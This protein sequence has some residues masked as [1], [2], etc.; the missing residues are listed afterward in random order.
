MAAEPPSAL[1]SLAEALPDSPGV[2]TFHGDTAAPLYIGKSVNIRRRV[3][4]HLRAPAGARL[5]RLTQRFS[6]V[7]TAGDIGAQLLEA[8][9]V[10]LLQPLFNLRLRRNRR[11]CTIILAGGTPTITN[12]HDAGDATSF[13]LFPSRLAAT[14][15]LRKLADDHGL[16][17]G[18]LGIETLAAGR[19]CFRYA[20]KRCTG[21]CC[22]EET[23]AE[24]R[25]RLI[26]ALVHRHVQAW[27]YQ[28]SIGIIEKS[29]DLRQ[30]LVVR[31]WTYLGSAAT[32]AQARKLDRP[33]TAFDRDGYRIL[34]QPLL[35]R[36]VEVREL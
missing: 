33:A 9:Q 22:G 16:C 4:E 3:L 32:L 31:N 29:G 28:G 30:I 10:K 15:V 11:L 13:G 17:Y 20:L 24:H 5:R 18:R 14:E 12:V 35:S 26:G 36:T 7:R 27:P 23:E 21:V 25:R 6:F 19:S 2:Y 34:V 8:Q 1:R